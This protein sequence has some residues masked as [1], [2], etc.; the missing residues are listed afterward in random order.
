MT[1]TRFA[2]IEGDDKPLSRI[3]AGQWLRYRQTAQGGL[4]ALQIERRN[5]EPVLFLP[6]LG[7]QFCP[8]YPVSDRCI[9]TVTTKKPLRWLF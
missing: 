9:T 1:S 6:P 5:G 2:A 7:W 3:K 4:D 8:P